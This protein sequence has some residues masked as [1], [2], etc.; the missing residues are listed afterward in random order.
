MTKANLDIY[1]Q[2]LAKAVNLVSIY[3]DVGGDRQDSAVYFIDG[4]IFQ[5]FPRK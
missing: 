1:R 2:H 5:I 3:K 4:A